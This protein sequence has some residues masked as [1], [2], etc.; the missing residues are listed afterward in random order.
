MYELVLELGNLDKHKLFIAMIGVYFNMGD[1]M[2]LARANTAE[3]LEFDLSL[4]RVES[5]PTR[6]DR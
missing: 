5:P 4:Y 3:F 1:D 2:L 6:H